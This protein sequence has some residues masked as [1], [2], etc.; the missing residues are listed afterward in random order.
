MFGQNTAYR[1]RLILCVLL[2]FV[3][4]FLDHRFNFMNPVRFSLSVVTAPIHY[5][6]NI[7]QRLLSWSGEGM[8]SREDLEDENLRLQS[9]VLVLKRRVQ[10]LAST[11]AENTRLKELMNASDLLDD[12]VL[13]AEIIGVDPDPYRHEAI[14]DKGARDNV[15]V[16]QAVL[17]AEGLMGQVIEVGLLSSRVLLISDI[18]HGLPVHVNRNGVRAIAVGS[19]KL[20]LLNLIHVPDTADIARGDLLVSSGLGGRFPKGYP[21]G[22]VTKV[23]HDPGRPFALVEAKPMA[24]LDRSRHVLLVFSEE[25][26]RMLPLSTEGEADSAPPQGSAAAPGSAAPATAPPA[27]EVADG[28]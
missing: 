25:G 20:D 3:L 17:D 13:I 2:S 27:E 10:K 18:S 23:E 19:G 6:A 16:G 22:V 28:D 8:R 5:V 7:P 12:Q 24:N 1:Y 11:V 4:I 26:R 14:I 15:Y 21:V 9:E